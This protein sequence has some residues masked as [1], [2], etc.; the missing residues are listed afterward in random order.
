MS[1][2]FFSIVVWI[3]AWA[4][5]VKLANGTA[6]GTRLVKV[7]VPTLF[8][9]TLLLVWEMLV[10]GLNVPL[11]IL[12]PPSLVIDTMADNLA[13]LWKDFVQTFLKGA[14]RGYLMGCSAAILTAFLLR[15]FHTLWVSNTFW[16]IN[17][18]LIII[19][20]NPAEARFCSYSLSI[21]CNEKHD[22]SQKHS[23]SYTVTPHNFVY[24]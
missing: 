11:V 12:P 2:V 10:R 17:S 7:I 6:S 15:F 20:Q 22:K 24:F 3:A 21:Y 1:I 9:L 18:F 5:N 19:T 8:G 14:L 13:I 16:H 4:L 23:I